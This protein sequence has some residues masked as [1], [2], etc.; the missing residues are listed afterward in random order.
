MSIEKK[1]DLL[2]KKGGRA[3]GLHNEF[4]NRCICQVGK[5]R[6]MSIEKPYS[7]K[8]KFFHIL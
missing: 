1:I 7:I 6:V 5:C 8:M 3:G 4:R 2:K